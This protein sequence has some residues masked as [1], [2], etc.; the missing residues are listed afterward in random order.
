MHALLSI[1]LSAR[2]RLVSK[3][4][5]GQTLV[6]YSLILAV[7][8]IL[9]IGVFGALGQKVIYVFS[10]ITSLLDTAQGS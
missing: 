2:A 9:A 8:S 6:E 5:S 10:Q 7:I 1:F 4:C 3:K